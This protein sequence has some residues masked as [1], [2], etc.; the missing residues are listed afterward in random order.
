MNVT[1][2]VFNSHCQDITMFEQKPEY[3]IWL[4][5]ISKVEGL[6]VDVTWVS[7]LIQSLIVHGCEFLNFLI[8][9]LN[10]PL[11]GPYC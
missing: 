1:Y 5:L 7:F 3:L 2:H 8:N 10:N 4:C 9:F 6:L 11:L